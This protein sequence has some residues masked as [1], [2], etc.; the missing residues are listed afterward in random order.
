VLWLQTPPW[1]R[2][3]AAALIAIGALW[4]EL[5]PEPLVLHPFA[6]VDIAVGEEIGAWNSQTREVLAGLF[7]DV[8]AEGIAEVAIP[9]G[10]PI[11]AS[12]LAGDAAAIP[13]GWWRFDVTLPQ[14]ADRGDEARVILVDSGESIA[15][16]VASGA[17]DDPL[18]TGMGSVAVEPAR[19]AEVAAAASDGRVAIMVL[20]P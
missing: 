15:A 20:T 3:I 13:S 4:V 14:G 18:G 6:S 7:D 9:E 17:S 16:V 11:L 10:D 2:W 8:T 19:A 1:G 12:Q 5:R